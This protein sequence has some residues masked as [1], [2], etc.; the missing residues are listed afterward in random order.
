[1]WLEGF[2]AL[3]SGYEFWVRRLFNVGVNISYLFR[4]GT[5]LA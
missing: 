2:S 5:C 4:P 3:R 1:M